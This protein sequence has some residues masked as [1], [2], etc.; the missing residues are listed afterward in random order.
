MNPGALSDEALAALVTEAQVTLQKLGPAR[1]EL[2]DRVRKF[3]ELYAA[4]PQ[5]PEGP[6]LLYQTPDSA[7]VECHA[8]NQRL[9]VGRLSRR[10]QNAAGCDLTFKDAEMS[11]IHFEIES[12]EG[13]YI[14][15]DRG[16]RNGTLLNQQPVG[17]EEAILKA[18][19]IISAGNAIFIFTGN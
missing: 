10:E 5:Q 9:V 19:D 12:S 8:I 13:F 3:G 17:A 1:S 2:L 4:L 15:R 16:S 7:K 6:A 14:L 11:R 18:G